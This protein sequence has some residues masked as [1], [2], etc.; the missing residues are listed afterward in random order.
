MPGEHQT[1]IKPPN[2]RLAG[3]PQILKVVP[4]D[5]INDGTHHS[6]RL[7]FDSD[8]EQTEAADRREPIRVFRFQADEGV[9]DLWSRGSN[10]PS[11]HSQWQS[12]KVSTSPVVMEAP[13]K[14][15]RTKP[16]RLLAR[17][18]RTFFKPERYFSRG[19]FKCASG[20]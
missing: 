17:I 15:A 2:L 7:L 12:K 11:W 13:S 10:Q 9:P 4:L 14:R 1:P 16:S 8:G 6:G 19:S 18:R 20:V 5:H 3:V